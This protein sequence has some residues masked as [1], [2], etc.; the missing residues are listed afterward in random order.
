MKPHKDRIFVKMNP[1]EVANKAGIILPVSMQ[2]KNIGIVVEIGP[3]VKKIKVG[4]K[5]KKW[6]D[7]SGPE[8][9]FEGQKVL[10]LRES[11]SIEFIL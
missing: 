6:N 7:V 10:I 5:I 4:D 2:E 11:E 8:I 9:E 3:E 1:S